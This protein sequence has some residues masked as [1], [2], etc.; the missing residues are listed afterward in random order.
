[1]FDAALLSGAN[2]TDSGPAALRSLKAL[3]GQPAAGL[4]AAITV[5]PCAPVKVSL[6]RAD[7]E[8]RLARGDKGT[9]VLRTRADQKI[10]D[11]IAVHI[12][13]P[14]HRKPEIAK[15]ACILGVRVI[16]SNYQAPIES[17]QDVSLAL[18]GFGAHVLPGRSHQ[19]V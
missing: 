18:V 7:E 15:L 19:E 4:A 10:G 16:E 12:P 6:G 2:A 17:A 5:P 11:A 3:D 14:I 8:H 1:M 13:C 9:Y